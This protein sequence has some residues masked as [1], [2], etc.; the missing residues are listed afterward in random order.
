MIFY[1][2]A[3]AMQIEPETDAMKVHYHGQLLYFFKKFAKLLSIT[4]Y[5]DSP[6]FGDG[7]GRACLKPEKSSNSKLESLRRNRGGNE[8][9]SRDSHVMIPKVDSQKCQL[10]RR[11]PRRRRRWWPWYWHPLWLF[12][13]EYRLNKTQR[14]ALSFCTAHMDTTHMHT[15]DAK[16]YPQSMSA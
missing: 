15:Q 7:R 9:Y 5:S 11:W 13:L 2:Q 4:P 3:L 16:K 8:Q 14:S 6:Y 1:D 12:Q 10:Y